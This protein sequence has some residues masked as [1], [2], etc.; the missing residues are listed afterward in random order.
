MNKTIKMGIVGT[1]FISD[2]MVDALLAVNC[3]TPYAVYSRTKEKGEA[4]AQRH[5]IEKVYSDYQAFLKDDA[6]D[7][8]YVATPNSTHADFTTKAIM[9]GKHVLCE[10][11]MALC[12]A[13]FD[14]LTSLA[15]AHGVVLIEAMRPAFDPAYQV[16]KTQMEKLGKLRYAC[17][18][19]CQY[20]SRYDAFL[21]GEVLRAFDPSFGNAALM[22]IGVYPLHVALMLFGKPRGTHATS[23][24]LHNGFEGMGELTLTYED[25]LANVRYSKITQSSQPSVIT[26]EKGSLHIDKLSQ[27]SRLSYVANNGK[28][29]EIPYTP[30]ENNMIFE[31]EAFVRYIREGQLCAPEMTVSRWTTEQLDCARRLLGIRFSEEDELFFS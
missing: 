1:N 13:E 26:G 27:P 4:F 7:A 23:V 28:I 25:M 10:N 16:V 21:G 3:A 9:A 30:P 19:F 24:F 2:R 14:R 31:V 22:D 17:L 29:T 5:H 8:V 6:L 11:P 18:D 15:K 20:S 12:T